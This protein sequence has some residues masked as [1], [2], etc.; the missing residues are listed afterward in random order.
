MKKIKLTPTYEWIVEEVDQYGDIID[1]TEFDKLTRAVYFAR[2]I[3]GN[4]MVQ[5]A[6]RRDVGN[7]L[8]GLIERDYWYVHAG[9]FVCAG[10]Q[11]PKRF[12][13]GAVPKDFQISEELASE[14]EK[15]S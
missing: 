15:L 9:E 8:E 11:P 10:I 4:V 6:L 12:R 13:A 2:T 7:D 3:G 14:L 5:I 1:A